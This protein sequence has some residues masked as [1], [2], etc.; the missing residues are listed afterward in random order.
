MFSILPTWYFKQKHRQ[1]VWNSRDSVLNDA[2]STKALSWA[3]KLEL[4][5]KQMTD[6][7][8]H[9]FLKQYLLEHI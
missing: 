4:R 9:L 7:V 3:Q 8:D 2:T 6:E 5:E 1:C